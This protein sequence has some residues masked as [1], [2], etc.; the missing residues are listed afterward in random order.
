MS[1]FMNKINKT[2]LGLAAAALGAGLLIGNAIAQRGPKLD[3]Q[4]YVDI[5]QLIDGYSRILENCTNNGNDYANM[6]TNDA[7]FGVSSTWGSGVK[8]WF[9]G[10]DQLARAGGAGPNGMC[11]PPLPNPEYH[12]VANLFVAPTAEGA[13]A[14]S[15]L[16]TI[17]N[18]TTKYGDPIHWE[19]GY[20]DTLVKTADGWRFKSRV[21]V[22]P[23]IKW[24]DNPADMPPRDLEK[25]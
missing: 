22:W 25:E 6:Y 13:K 20:E 19:G 16:L 4:D 15:T 14:T 8:W 3:A 24:T 7:Q 9:K 17:Q 5:R 10:R 18:K 23:E 2:S 12:I 21:H 1:K 11:R